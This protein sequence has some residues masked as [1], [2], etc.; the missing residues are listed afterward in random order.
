MKAWSQNV[1]MNVKKDHT[2]SARHGLC[3]KVVCIVM[4]IKLL[5]QVSAIYP[6]LIHSKLESVC[7]RVPLLPSNMPLFH[8]HIG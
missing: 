2:T 8:R 6:V 5:G 7:H 1:M 4:V 3:T